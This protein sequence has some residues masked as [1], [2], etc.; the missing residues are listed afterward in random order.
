MYQCIGGNDR[1]LHGGT[2]S[3]GAASVTG[4]FGCALALAGLAVWTTSLAISRRAKQRRLC[5]PALFLLALTPLPQAQSRAQ[6]LPQEHSAPQALARARQ[7]PLLLESFVRAMPKGGDLHM[8][9][10]GAV[11]AETYI[12]DAGEDGLCVDTNSLSLA[13]PQ[14]GG[15]CTP[16]QVPAAGVPSDQVLYDKLI[17]AFSMRSF[18][19]SAGF[20]GHDQFFATF[21]HFRGIK[22]SHSGEWLA[23]VANRAAGQNESYLEIMN[24]PDFSH[25]AALSAK[26]GWPS[27][28]GITPDF[29][30]M[31]GKLLADGLRDDVSAITGEIAAF[32]SSRDAI[33]HCGQPS[34]APGCTIR[35]RYLFQVLRGFPPQVVFAQTLLG[36]ETVSAEMAT[37]NARYVGINFVMPEDGYISMRDYHLQ[38]RMLDYLHAAYPQVHISLHAG[39]IV[40]GLVPPDGLRFHIREAVDLG[41]AE[42]IGHGVDALHEDNPHALLSEMARKHV[43]VEINITSND[44]ILGVTGIHHPLPEYLAAGVPVALSTDDEGVSRID[45]THEYVRAVTDFGL[46]YADL[47]KSARASL[48]HSFLPGESLWKSPDRFTVPVAACTAQSLGSTAPAPACATY[49]ASS[50]KASAQWDLEARYHIFELSLLRLGVARRPNVQVWAP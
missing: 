2:P 7:N 8:H 42:R 31:R 36:F 13:Q 26:I 47:K 48:E 39:E 30:A 11:Y 38:M 23:E 10:G 16:G 44:V 29:A 14:A 40:P 18:V 28:A 20:S 6:P 4:Y 35:M 19:A 17:D 3:S 27:D 25:A 34:A 5:L 46:G 22:G 15:S 41:H 21:G 24:T 9:L 33:D 32:E 49:L 43:M 50:A 1:A 12:K 45:L 37:G